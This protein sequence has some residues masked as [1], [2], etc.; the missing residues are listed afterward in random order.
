MNSDLIY[1][2]NKLDRIV[3]IE[4]KND[5]ALVFRE[6]EDGSIDRITIPHKYWILSNQSHSGKWFRLNG[7]QHYKWGKQYTKL[8]DYIDEKKNLKKEDIYTCFNAV[9]GLMIKDGV[10]MFKN[11]SHTELSVLSFDIETTGLTHDETSKVLL[12]SNT[13]RKKGQIIRRLFCYDEYQNC[14]EMIEAWS[15]WVRSIDPSLLI[16]HNG[17][18]FD[19]PYLQYCYSLYKQGNIKLGR[20][21][22][23]ITIQ[24]WESNFRVDGSRDLHYK[25]A[26]VYGRQ[27]VD[28][29]FL[30]YRYDLS[31]K[32]DSYGLKYIISKE[33]LEVPGRV[34]YDAGTIRHNYKNPEEW[35]KIKEY[36]IHD[37]DDA[38]A[39]YDLTVPPFFYMTQMIPKTFQELTCSASG[40]QLN[41]WMVRSYLQNKESI[42][43]ASPKVDFEG[44]ISFG[45]PGTYEN[46]VSLDIASLYPSIML[47]YNISDTRKDPNNHMLQFLDYMR[48]ERL[49][50]KKL[51]KETGNA[52]YQHLDSSYKILINS[53]YGFLGATG[54]HYNF[55]AG[56]AE[57]TR[58]G[59][60][61]LLTSIEW[62]KSKG[63][64]VPKGDT[65]SI[66]LW[67]KG[68]K[69]D[70][71]E[72]DKLIKEV[73]GIL[74]EQIN[75]ELDAF[76]DSIV[77]FKAKNYAYREGEKISTKGS[78]IKASTKCPALKEF[79][80]TILD[81]MLYNKPVS[82]MVAVY[83]KYMQEICDIK[84]I[85][86]WASRKTLSETMETSERTNETKVMDALED[87]DYK[88]GDR[89]YTFYK[90]DDT[91]CLV[92]NFD[93]DYNKKR[94]LKNLFDTM[95]IF[96]T[97]I[98]DCEEL[99][100]N[101]SL[102]KN[103]C[104]L[105]G[106]VAPPPKE[107]KPRVSKTKIA[108]L[109]EEYQEFNYMEIDEFLEMKG[110]QAPKKPEVKDSFM[111]F[112]ADYKAQQNR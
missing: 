95:M 65:D 93:G 26:N 70:G 80:K 27:I 20:D 98:P 103:Q 4:I 66:T 86:R 100:I 14:G 53:L 68:S 2:K 9:E 17:L 94:L 76:Y 64:T 61:T 104:L 81:L 110:I 11:M 47:Q 112:L 32:Y 3:S 33:G 21:D 19:L 56:A 37:A 15:N 35:Q 92:E 38:L 69:F 41:G 36:C 111:L 85:K 7:N 59:R 39:V 34:F 63:Y 77:V 46:A 28:T 78:A 8:K 24:N 54:L 89:F 99:F 48:T 62:A 44:A 29:M 55:P 74:P 23:E 108:Q 88:E 16:F 84:D 13:F 6:L 50:N 106:Y 45:E 83:N 96:E 22:Q 101:Y 73:N 43:K 91:I 57:V 72:V 40:A 105:P 58:R 109:F 60:E 18:N 75:F 25:K 82:E 67:D 79:I 12:I 30:A 51:A 97:V 107:K 10:T 1:G 102:K 87:S 49:K 31:R 5:E 42:P 71:L 52:F 90:S